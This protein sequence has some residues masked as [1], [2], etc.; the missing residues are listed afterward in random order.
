ML[1]EPGD[2]TRRTLRLA[3][4]AMLLGGLA[5]AV[6]VELL[7]SM[8]GRAGPSAVAATPSAPSVKTPA[9]SSFSGIAYSP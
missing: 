7:A 5:A 6:D 4:G 2:G 8:D 3:P 9:V 1:L